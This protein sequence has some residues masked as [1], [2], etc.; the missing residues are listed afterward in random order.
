MESSHG[1]DGD[2]GED[3]G[4][5]LLKLVHH[6]SEHLV[7]LLLVL[8]VQLG[9]GEEGDPG[10]DDQGQHVEA[11]S[12]VGQHIQGGRELEGVHHVLEQEEPPELGGDLVEGLDHAGQHLGDGLGRNSHGDGRHLGHGVRA[13][14]SL[15]HH[16]HD[17]AVDLDTEHGHEEGEA[18]VGDHGDE[19]VGC[20]REQH[21]HHR[22]E[23]GPGLQGLL[24]VQD[25]R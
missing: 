9:S 8:Q 14:L 1:L 21:H 13:G 25:T 17:G 22:P 11:G 10:E 12:D 6:L 20:E 2:E 19:G 23:H 4:L 24:P 18:G 15:V 16:D 5:G 7:H 3:L